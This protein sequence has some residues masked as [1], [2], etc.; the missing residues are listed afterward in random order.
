MT[1]KTD[2][3][4]FLS[5]ELF[6]LL[7][8]V[9]GAAL[10]IALFFVGFQ[11]KLSPPPKPPQ[12][13]VKAASAAAYMARVDRT[14]AAYKEFLARDAEEAGV[15]VPSVDELSTY[16][17]HRLDTTERTLEPG[18]D[19]D[20]ELETAGLR[21]RLATR[22]IAGRTKQMMVL[23]VENLTDRALA[24]R[25]DTAPSRGTV[26]CAEKEELSHN[27]IALE[28]HGMEMRSECIYRK[29]WTL[30]VTRVETIELPPLS[31]HYVSRLFPAHIGLERRVVEG[32][33]VPGHRPCTLVLSAQVSRALAEGTTAWRDLIDFYARH[34]CE[35]YSF[36]DSYKAVEPGARLEL[37]A[38]GARR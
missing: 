11:G 35:T 8:G 6:R 27:A 7:V 28:P 14:P 17:E 4:G 22:D 16:F 23:Q 21:L 33:R 20:A 1:S 15:P 2:R 5:D 3:R 24:Y 13:V 31:Y 19:K 12:P 29:G 25:V 18:D 32:H 38:A 36:P 30:K 37:P 9:A 34:R 26:P 10:A